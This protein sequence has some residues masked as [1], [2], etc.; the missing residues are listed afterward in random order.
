[1]VS[2]DPRRVYV[3]DPKDVK[4]A[5]VRASK[6]GPNGEEW[7]W[8]Q[9]TINGGRAGRDLGA[10]ELAKAVEAL[11][12]GEILLNC[13][14]EDGQG[15]GF[16]LELV[17]QVSAAVRI[18]V[19]AS[20]GAGNPGHFADVFEGTECSA[21]LAAGIFHRKEVKR[22]THFARLSVAPLCRSWITLRLSCVSFCVLR[23]VRVPAGA[24]SSGCVLCMQLIATQVSIQEV[25]EHM[26]KSGLPTRL[27]EVAAAV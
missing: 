3:K 16:D 22:D 19:I 27:T 1:M 7:A 20:S 11:G 15:N 2:I 26:A 8:Y 24:D 6:K 9:C 17:R 4:H 18:P 21:A 5:C 25:K 14:D 10:L 13:I 23:S 12:A